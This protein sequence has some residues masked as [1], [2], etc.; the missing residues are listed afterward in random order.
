MRQSGSMADKSARPAK[1]YKRAEET[2]NE[3]RQ[4][5]PEERK[6]TS[7]PYDCTPWGCNDNVW[8]VRRPSVQIGKRNQIVIQ[9]H[10]APA[11]VVFEVAKL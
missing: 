8:R 9:C 11:A 3:T 10:N 2:T 5:R 1:H 6:N 7:A 4:T